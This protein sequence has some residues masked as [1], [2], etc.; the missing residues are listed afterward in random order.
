[1]IKGHTGRFWRP[2]KRT[3]QWKC[4]YIHVTPV[5]DIRTMS[6]IPILTDDVR[7]LGRRKQTMHADFCNR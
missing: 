1:M 7:W 2:L 5:F 6:I 4:G 3:K